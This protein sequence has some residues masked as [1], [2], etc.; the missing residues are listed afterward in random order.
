MVGPIYETIR[1][2]VVT[3]PAQNDLVGPVG[4][5][6]W[7]GLCLVTTTANGREVRAQTV[8]RA[9]DIQLGVTA[10]LVTCLLLVIAL[11]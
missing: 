9:D 2:V 7:H 1:D 11:A 8:E 3:P 5:A 10:I 4:C 6:R